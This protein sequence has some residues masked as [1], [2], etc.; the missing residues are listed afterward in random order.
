MFLNHTQ[1]LQHVTSV[2]SSTRSGVRAVKQEVSKSFLSE[3]K[4]KETNKNK[5]KAIIAS[6]VNL[7]KWFR[8]HLTIVWTHQL[9]MTNSKEE[10][11]QGR[12]RGLIYVSHTLYI[13][14]PRTGRAFFFSPQKKVTQNTGMEILHWNKN[15]DQKNSKLCCDTV[16]MTKRGRH[17]ETLSSCHNKIFYTKS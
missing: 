9:T 7:V 6:L 1:H 4:N 5:K 14:E 12:R 11:E 8:L 17:H 2:S 3:I 15:E 10:E 16:T 13:Y